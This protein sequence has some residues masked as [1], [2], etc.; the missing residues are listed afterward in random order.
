MGLSGYKAEDKLIISRGG[1][2]GIDILEFNR[3]GEFIRNSFHLYVRPQGKW[4][5]LSYSVLFHYL[6]KNILI[7]VLQKPGCGEPGNF[8]GVF[9]YDMDDRKS[10]SMREYKV[11]RSLNEIGIHSITGLAVRRREDTP[12]RWVVVLSGVLCQQVGAYILSFSVEKDSEG[13]IS[14]TEISRIKLDEGNPESFFF[15]DDDKVVFSTQRD[16]YIISASEGKIIRKVEGEGGG[17]LFVYRGVIYEFI[18][19]GGYLTIKTFDTNLNKIRDFPFYIGIYP[20]VSKVHIARVID[21]FFGFGELDFAFVGLSSPELLS[22]ISAL[23]IF[24]ATNFV[25]NRGD[26]EIFA[27]TPGEFYIGARD[28]LFF[29]TGRNMVFLLDFSGAIARVFLR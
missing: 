1:T 6:D 9:I 26:I 22:N 3:D 14:F 28:F 24:D 27:I 21:E 11:Y 15:I 25:R 4:A 12:H 20:S 8:S 18:S 13:R 7:A 17:K 2:G 10:L 5:D 29:R 19:D 23:L 16:I